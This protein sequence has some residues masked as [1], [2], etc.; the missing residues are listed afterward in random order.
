M[1]RS[2]HDCSDIERFFVHFPSP[3]LGVSLRQ[4]TAL[5]LQQAKKYPFLNALNVG[6]YSQ[7]FFCFVFLF[8]PKAP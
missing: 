6:Q 3:H 8:M 5:F 2:E 4:L 7:V 1:Q